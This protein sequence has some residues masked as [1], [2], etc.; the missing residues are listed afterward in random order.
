M[1]LSDKKF[2]LLVIKY[3]EPWKTYYYYTYYYTRLTCSGSRVGPWPGS[4]ARR[5]II[6]S[7][8]FTVGL[9][10]LMLLVPPLHSRDSTLIFYSKNTS[11]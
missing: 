1:I 7:S 2:E 9:G 5:K 4:L 11:I 3:Q 6:P 10:C 8:K